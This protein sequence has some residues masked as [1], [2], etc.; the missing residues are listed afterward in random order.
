MTP[1]RTAALAKAMLA[2][3][4]CPQCRTDAG[5]CIPTSL[6]ICVSCAYPDAVSRAA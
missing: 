2:R 3:R 5:Y 4:T 1:A 6:G